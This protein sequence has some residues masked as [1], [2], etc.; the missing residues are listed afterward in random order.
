MSFFLL[1]YELAIIIYNSSLPLYIFRKKKLLEFLRVIDRISNGN[2]AHNNYN[3]RAESG[4]GLG[5]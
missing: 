4:V 1:T 3:I 2:S 5:P